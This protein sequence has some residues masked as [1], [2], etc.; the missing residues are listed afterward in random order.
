MLVIFKIW[1][2]LELNPPVSWGMTSVYHHTQLL[3]VK[4][5]ERGREREKREAFGSK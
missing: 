5:G 2:S 4:M 1:A 3:L